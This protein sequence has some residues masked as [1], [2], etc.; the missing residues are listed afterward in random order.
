[1]FFLYNLL[2]F[3]LEVSVECKIDDVKHN[4]L[5]G[6]LVTCITDGHIQM[7]NPLS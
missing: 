7:L 2:N 1:M 3:A 4:E 5:G 6:F